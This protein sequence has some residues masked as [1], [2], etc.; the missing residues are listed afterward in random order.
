MHLALFGGTGRVGSLLLD[1]TI[2][3]GHTINALVR[4]TARLRAKGAQVTVIEGTLDDGESVA[5]TL[6]NTDA[7]LVCL[8]AGNDTLRLFDAAAIPVMQRLGPKRIVSMVGA[9]VRRPGDP[10]TA[11]LR[12]MN[13]MMRLVPGRLL[14]DADGHARRLA[15]S[16]LDWTLVRSANHYD[17]PGPGAVHA[18]AHFAMGLGARISRSNLAAFMLSVAVDGRFIGEAPMVE[19]ADHVRN[20][21]SGQA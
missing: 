13:V 16:G 12:I 3:Y 8:A 6:A 17:A 2:G 9:S 18:E 19:S 11:A 15:A 14:E 7:A 10:D 5:A 20:W 4:D 1:Q 21:S